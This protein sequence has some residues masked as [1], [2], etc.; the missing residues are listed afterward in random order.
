MQNKNPL[1]K[2]IF[3]KEKDK[4]G[5][6]TYGVVYKA[7]NSETGLVSTFSPVCSLYF[8]F[9]FILKLL[10]LSSDSM[11]NLKFGSYSHIIIIIPGSSNEK[12]QT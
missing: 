2:Y 9:T 5:E 7:T 6:G 11:R 10:V 1:D 8:V 3:S 12:D 4:L